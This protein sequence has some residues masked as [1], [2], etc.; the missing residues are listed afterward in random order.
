MSNCYTPVE[1]STAE[2]ATWRLIPPE[3]EDIALMFGGE[4]EDPGLAI[5]NTLT[6]AA[7]IEATGDE[8]IAHLADWQ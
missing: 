4:G 6:P 2:F 5:E 3:S 7:W 1:E 8:S